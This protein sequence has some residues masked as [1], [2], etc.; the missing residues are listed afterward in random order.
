M[1]SDRVDSTARVSG[2]VHR[3][4]DHGGLIFVDLRDRTGLVQLVLDPDEVGGGEWSWATGCGPRTCSPRAARSSAGTARRSTR[5]SP[6]ASS[7]SASP[8]P[9]CWPTRTRRRSRSRASPARSGRRCGFATAT[10]T[11]AASRC[12]RRIELRARV[13]RAMREFFDGEGF[14]EIETPELT[15]STPEGARDFLVPSRREPGA[16]YA[17]PQS[18]QLFKQLLMV[19]GFERYYQ[20]AR[21]FRDEAMR[22][23]RQAEFTQLDVEMSFVTVDDVIDVNERMLAHVFERVGGPGDRAA[24]RADALRRGDGALRHRP[25][26]RP[27]RAGAAD[28]LGR[29][30]RDGVQGLPLGARV[31]RR[32]PRSERGAARRAAL[33]PRRADR[34]R[35][36]A[37]GEGT[38]V[39]VP[40]GRGVALADGEVPLRR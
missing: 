20:I 13:A 12:A 6:P 36:G 18:P 8:R 2:W 27:L 10:S 21:C 40:G 1:L 30:P 24:A 3:R 32:G 26:R 17:L 39:G 15:R 5:S 28:A 7:R 9:S 14:L 19:S 31:R 25:S 35:P 38:R 22:S 34:A 33:G 4:R 23:D 16:F 11:C 29:G 37:R